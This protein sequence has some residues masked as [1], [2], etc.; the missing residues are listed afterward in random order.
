L[1]Y[2]WKKKV[3]MDAKDLFHGSLGEGGVQA[4]RS[5]S[6]THGDSEGGAWDGHFDCSCFHPNFLFN[7]F[8]ML[9]R[10]ALRN[11]NVHCAD[12]CRKVLSH[13]RPVYQA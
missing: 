1:R 3:L 7:Q 5:V 11:G 12:G 10:W 9:E 8:G 13:H 2:K 6:S 4:G